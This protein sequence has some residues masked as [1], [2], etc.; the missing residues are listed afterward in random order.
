MNVEYLR[1]RREREQEENLDELNAIT[2]D[3]V[4]R[5]LK[6]MKNGKAVEPYNL[7]IEVWKVL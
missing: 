2:E 4:K 1:E 7:P 5:S 6:R 3:E